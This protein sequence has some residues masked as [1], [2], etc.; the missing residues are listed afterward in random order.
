MILQSSL[1]QVAISASMLLATT[2]VAAFDPSCGDGYTGYSL[3]LGT[4]C[5][6]YVYCSDG[7]IL[8]STTCPGDTIYSGNVGVGGVC[9]FSGPGVCAEESASFTVTTT[10]TTAATSAAASSSGDSN[11]ISINVD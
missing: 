3:K 9:T 4:Q 1:L 8:S 10:T 7:M 11:T 5:R 6:Q 2:S